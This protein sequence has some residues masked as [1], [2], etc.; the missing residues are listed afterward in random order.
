LLHAFENVDP[1]DPFVIQQQ[2]NAIQ[3]DHHVGTGL[4]C[5]RHTRRRGVN[6]IAQ[7]L[8]VS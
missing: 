3:A 6:P 8:S 4:D 7:L 5:M 2:R 1:G